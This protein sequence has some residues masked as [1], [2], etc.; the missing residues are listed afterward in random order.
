[1]S[2]AWP[3]RRNHWPTWPGF[4]CSWWST[5]STGFL[6]AA[7]PA[8][9]ALLLPPASLLPVDLASNIPPPILPRLQQP[10]NDRNHNS[11]RHDAHGQRQHRVEQTGH[12]HA[13]A[14]REPPIARCRNGLG[15]GR[16][17]ERAVEAVLAAHACMKAGV[18]GS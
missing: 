16:K 18:Y 13:K 7:G 8:G 15:R 4:D 6:A 11:M 14:E 9:A 17:E 2:S 10:S 1:M 5:S 3:L 12:H